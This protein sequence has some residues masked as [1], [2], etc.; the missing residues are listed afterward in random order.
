M[1]KQAADI[2]WLVFL[3]DNLITEIEADYFQLTD[4]W[5]YQ[6]YVHR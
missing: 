2:K 3:F 4:N 1:T 5:K 6:Q